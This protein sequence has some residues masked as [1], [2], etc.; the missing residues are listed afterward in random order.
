M[1]NENIQN[2]NTEFSP[3]SIL[4][5]QLLRDSYYF[6]DIAAT[7]HATLTR[8]TET[9]ILPAISSRFTDIL[10]LKGANSSVNAIRVDIRS[11][12]GGSII[13]SIVLPAN[14][15]REFTFDIPLLASEPNT[16]WTGQINTSGEVSDSPISITLVAVKNI[17]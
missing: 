4:T 10:K 9:T 8:G 2:I 13:D 3:T 11:G 16:P 5:Q 17:R 1:N 7:G 6:R 12:T 14:D 15:T